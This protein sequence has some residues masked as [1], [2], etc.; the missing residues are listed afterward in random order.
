MKT[1]RTEQREAEDKAQERME[2]MSEEQRKAENKAQE[3]MERMER[4]REEERAQSENTQAMFLASLRMQQELLGRLVQQPQNPSS[5]NS[6]RE[7]SVDDSSNDS[8][9]D[10]MKRGRV[11]SVIRQGHSHRYFRDDFRDG[12]SHESSTSE[13]Q[14]GNKDSFGM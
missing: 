1:M 12:R 5:P 3:R 2:K 10:S 4:M 14:W 6:R 8:D 7:D 9:D 11:N 13:E